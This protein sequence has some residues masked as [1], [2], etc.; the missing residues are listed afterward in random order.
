MRSLRS[1]VAELTGRAD[2]AEARIRDGEVLVAGAVVTNPAS[3][4]PAGAAVTIRAE[5]VLRGRRKLGAAL[6]HWEVPLAGAVA[7]DAGAAAGGFTQA[8]LDRGARKV[9]A[10]EV[11]YGQLLG[12][13]R[14]DPRVVVLERVNIAEL[15]RD[16]VPDPL[17]AVTL[18]LGYLALASG[19]PQLNGLDISPGAELIALVK[20]MFELG[21]GAPPSDRPTLD[22][23]LTSA[24]DG[25]ERAGW[26]VVDSI[27]S[28]VGGSKGAREFFVRARRN[29]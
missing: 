16:L 27:D 10:V 17:E 21:L 19:V 28:E 13:L 24:T 2:E 29:G 20:P 12:S 26:T 15:T 18:D 5:H 4:V 22:L 1:R 6:D 23:A 8:L 7:L 14:Q 9:Y 3:M 11:G 25:I